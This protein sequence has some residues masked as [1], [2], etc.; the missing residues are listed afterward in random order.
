MSGA[1]VGQFKKPCKAYFDVKLMCFVEHIEYDPRTRCGTL[2]LPPCNCPN[3]SDAI[4][5]FERIDHRV[6][7]I[8]TY[9]GKQKDGRYQKQDDGAWIA[10]WYRRKGA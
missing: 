6:L 4:K 1:N 10:L 3:M 8:E 7:R 5:L 2:W 9:A